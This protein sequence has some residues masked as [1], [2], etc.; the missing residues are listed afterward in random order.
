MRN[1]FCIAAIAFIIL[2]SCSKDD[3]T[4]GEVRIFPTN[5]PDTSANSSGS[6]FSFSNAFTVPLAGQFNNPCMN[7]VFMVK[8]GALLIDV[9]GVYNAHG[10]KI[11]I[12]TNVKGSAAVGSGGQQYILSGASNEHTSEFYNGVFITRLQHL[13]RWAPGNRNNIIIKDIYYIKV[14]AER[15]VTLTKEPVS[16]V[17]CR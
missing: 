17:Y 7:D 10:S 6:T 11:T 2:S 1:T 16:D 4:L 5:Q 14:D 8:A 15:K 9:H 3:K 12:Y 13:S